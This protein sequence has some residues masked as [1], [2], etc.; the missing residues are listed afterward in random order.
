MRRPTVRQILLTASLMAAAWMT[1]R[2][3]TS[4]PTFEVIVDAPEGETTIRC[5]RGCRLAWVERGV[6][7]AVPEPDFKFACRGTARCS[8]Y[9]VGGWVEAEK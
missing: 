6:G 7:I 3:Q 2:A 8:S 4:A 5:V 9:R 1:G